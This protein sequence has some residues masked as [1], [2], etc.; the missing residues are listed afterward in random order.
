MAKK[1]KAKT[2]KTSTKKKKRSS[3]K[4]YRSVEGEIV[5]DS[6]IEASHP[7]D[8]SEEDPDGE[9]SEIENSFEDVDDIIINAI[10]SYD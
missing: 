9:L 3:L 5:D 8:L 6:S 2:K 1:K 10:E 7:E 4:G